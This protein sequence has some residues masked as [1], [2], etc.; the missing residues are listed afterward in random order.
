MLDSHPEMAVPPET[1]FIVRFAKNQSRYDSSGVFAFADFIEDL[2]DTGG[3][4][5]MCL[6]EEALRESFHSNP[7]A[8]YPDAI[9]GV[10]RLYALEQGKEGYGDKTPMYV[11]HIRQLGTLFP[12]A[13][14]VH[15]IR[16]GRDVARSF[17]DGGWADRIE[18]ATLYWK[19]Q[20]VRGRRAGQRLGPERY[21]EVRYEDLVAD[22]ESVLTSIC[23]YLD[24]AFDPG[25]LRY[26]E[27][28]RHW[29]DLSSQPERH[30]HTLLQPTAGLRDWRH[31]MPRRD[32]A[33]VELLAGDLLTD[34]GYELGSGSPS[35]GVRLDG[36]RRWLGWQGRRTR[37][38]LR[39]A[40]IVP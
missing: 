6:S 27:S 24:V 32:L 34:L 30:R 17:M 19:L 28:A 5:R 13:R 9:R 33:V 26:Q 25:M 22:P 18:D 39:R 8:T 35:L 36:T 15:I 14:F 31:E 2:V 23:E 12:E 11:L 4:K 38:H 37:G 29:A 21:R 10:F 3:F 20:V 40:S 16:D 7:P 1:Y